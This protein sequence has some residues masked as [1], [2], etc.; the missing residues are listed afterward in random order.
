M[1]GVNAVNQGSECRRL[2]GSG[3]AGHQD[4][5]VAKVRR[6]FQL[7]G[8]PKRTKSWNDGWNDAHHNR[9]TAA[10][11]ENIE[12]ETRHARQPIGNV[13]RPLLAQSIDGLLVVAD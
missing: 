7:G 2:A 12:A 5:A 11:N 1:F 3:P 10:L 4:D 13:T 9:A 6:F 8:K